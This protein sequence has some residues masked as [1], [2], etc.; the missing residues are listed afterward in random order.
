MYVFWSTCLIF[1]T[2]TTLKC[3][4]HVK[5]LHIIMLSK[6]FQQAKEKECCCHC[7][8]L[9]NILSPPCP[10]FFDFE[11]FYKTS[12]SHTLAWAGAACERFEADRDSIHQPLHLCLM[13][14][15]RH[16]CL[17]ACLMRAYR[18][19]TSSF[20]VRKSAGSTA[21]GF[22]NGFSNPVVCWEVFFSSSPGFEAQAKNVLKHKRSLWL[23]PACHCVFWLAETF[24]WQ[25][26][27]VR[28]GKR[29][30]DA[31]REGKD[32]RKAQKMRCQAGAGHN[33]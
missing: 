31:S 14:L 23:P 20:Y 32:I 21:S 28:E 3:G 1:S 17:P 8:S 2:P 15:C 25:T 22:A 33:C 11:K 18:M 30:R 29:E 26:Q 16:S 10:F 6:Y 27:R 19:P 13:A 5:H 9:K 7:V 12:S 4:S 24:P